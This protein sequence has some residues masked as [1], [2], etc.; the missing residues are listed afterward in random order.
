M[1][2]KT[3]SGL[4]A[5]FESRRRANYPFLV[6][7][8]S[9]SIG[10]SHCCLLGSWCFS[11]CQGAVRTRR[12]SKCCAMRGLCRTCGS[13]TSAPWRFERQPRPKRGNEGF[14]RINRLAVEQDAPSCT[15]F[16]ASQAR[17]GGAKPIGHK[18]HSDRLRCQKVDFENLSIAAARLAKTSCTAAQ[19]TPYDPDRRLR[20]DHF[21]GRIR[22]VA[23]ETECRYT[24]ACHTGSL[25]A[26]QE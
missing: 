18:R 9:Q 6:Q 4:R 25:A 8:P 19:S 21:D 22:Q 17:R 11:L 12:F 3:S 24:V 23:R 1:S 14:P 5:F 16:T 26:V 15:R 7:T 20:L 13:E 2:L 10:S